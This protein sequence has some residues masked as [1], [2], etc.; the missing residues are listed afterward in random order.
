VDQTSYVGVVLG[1][2]GVVLTLIGLF[3]S[4]TGAEA[5][6]GVGVLQLLVVLTGL[7]VF[8]LGGFV[9]VKGTY[10]ADKAQ[11]L[12]QSIGVRLSLTGLVLASFAG[13]ADLLGFGTH[14]PGQPVPPLLGPWQATGIIGGF[15]IASLGVL[16]Y[17]AFGE[18]D[19]VV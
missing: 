8:I 16:V 7:S 11:T 5:S 18:R 13:F 2:F 10:Y 19:E 3:P 12:A 17:A 4:L 15:M 1:I 14:P 9:F 6:E